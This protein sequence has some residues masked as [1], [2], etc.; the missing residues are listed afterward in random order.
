MLQSVFLQWNR[1]N[2]A[3][4]L[5]IKAILTGSCCCS[6]C[7]FSFEPGKLPIVLRVAWVTRFERACTEVLNGKKC[8][9]C[10]ATGW[11]RCLM[12]RRPGFACVISRC[13]RSLKSWLLVSFE[14][15][16]V[17]C[18]LLFSRPSSTSTNN[19]PLDFTPL[20]RHFYSV[21]SNSNNLNSPLTR[22]KLPFPLSK[23][24]WNSNSGSFNSTRMPFH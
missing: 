10:Y 18:W 11:L 2:V 19:N 23:I 8:W 15:L 6:Y 1:W 3:N 16:V 22:A 12:E 9:K 7:W 14:K 17:G 5:C 24:H 13:R 4:S 20:F 21:N